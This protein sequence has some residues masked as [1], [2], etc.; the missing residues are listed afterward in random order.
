MT[1]HSNNLIRGGTLASFVLVRPSHEFGLV[2]QDHVQ[3]GIVEMRGRQL[4]AA[5]RFSC[6]SRAL[7][8]SSRPAS[9]VQLSAMAIKIVARL[10]EM[11]PSRLSA[12]KRLACSRH[13][14]EV[15]VYPE[16][17]CRPRSSHLDL[18]ASTRCAAT[19]ALG[20]RGAPKESGQ[21]P[22]GPSTAA[23]VPRRSAVAQ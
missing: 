10:T 2:V 15:I 23:D 16:A 8:R 22:P 20:R 1:R 11:P 12:A 17:A 19:N 13:S 4:E 3:K 6:A 9:L 7:S 18:A 5:Y 21:C 14:R